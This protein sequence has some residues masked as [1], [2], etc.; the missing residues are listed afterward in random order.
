MRALGFEARSA[1]GRLAASGIE[2]R[3][4]PPTRRAAVSDRRDLHISLAGATVADAAD[5]LYYLSIGR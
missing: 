2:F 3:L 5:D 1:G 4:S